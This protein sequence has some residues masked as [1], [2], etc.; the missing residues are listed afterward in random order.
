LHDKS[1]DLLSFHKVSEKTSNK[2][3]PSKTDFQDY[4]LASRSVLL[5][6]IANKIIS[7]RLAAGKQ[8]CLKECLFF[9]N[10]NG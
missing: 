6:S 4:F 9:G 1:P 7:G 5:I 8:F 2:T 10:Q 3:H